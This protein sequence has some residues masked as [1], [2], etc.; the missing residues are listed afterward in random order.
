[1]RINPFAVPLRSIRPSGEWPLGR[2]LHTCT[3]TNVRLAIPTSGLIPLPTPTCR[4]MCSCGYTALTRLSSR[5]LHTKPC[6]AHFA[7]ARGTFPLSLLLT[8]HYLQPFLPLAPTNG[9]RGSHPQ[10]RPRLG[11]HPTCTA[12]SS[13][14]TRRAVYCLAQDATPA[15]WR[16]Q[17]DHFRGDNFVLLKWKKRKALRPTL[18]CPITSAA[19]ILCF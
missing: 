5:A 11:A 12:F 3:R 1:M 17:S 7:R 6:H 18:D 9:S 15:Q 19:I 4:R 14:L 13:H 2:A 16:L 10:C 8:T